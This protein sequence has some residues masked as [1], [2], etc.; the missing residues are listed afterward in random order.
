MSPNKILLKLPAPHHPQY[1]RGR[2]SNFI[3][4]Y[5]GQCPVFQSSHIVS[6]TSGRSLFFNIIIAGEHELNSLTELRQ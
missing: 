1:W 5:N 4:L 6:V 2:V 3:T